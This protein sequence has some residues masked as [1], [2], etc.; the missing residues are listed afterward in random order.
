[1]LCCRLLPV[2]RVQ[3]R[4][5]AADIGLDFLHPALELGMR[6]V[7][8]TAVDCLELAAVD[9]HNRIREQVQLLAQHDKL[10]AHIADRFA[11]IFAEVHDRLEVRRQALRQPH[12][13]DITLRFAL[14]PTA[15]KTG[16]IQ[17]LSQTPFSLIA[18]FR[19]ANVSKFL[20]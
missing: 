10:P 7:S 18:S 14:E 17:G 19:S 20:I 1:M 13:L 4:E 3:F 11:I 9:R 6:E 5:I 16:K 2:S 12:Q 8:V 15:C